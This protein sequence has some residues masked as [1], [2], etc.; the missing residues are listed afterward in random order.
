MWE[1][2][3][4]KAP[5]G[6]EVVKHRF[7]VGLDSSYKSYAQLF[8]GESFDS[9]CNRL[10][11]WEFGFV[12]DNQLRPNQKKPVTQVVGVN[13]VATSTWKNDSNFKKR[14]VCFKFKEG[15]CT[16]GDRCKFSHPANK[17]NP[18]TVDT[19]KVPVAEAEKERSSKVQPVGV[20][21][22]GA[23]VSLSPLSLTLTGKKTPEKLCAN[24]NNIE[25]L[26]ETF[27]GQDD[28]GV[29]ANEEVPKSVELEISS[30][31]VSPVYFRGGFKAQ[32]LVDCGAACNLVDASYSNELLKSD[33][34]AVVRNLARPVCVIFGNSQS[35]FSQKVLVSRCRFTSEG[36]SEYHSFLIVPQLEPKMVLGRPELEA[37][38]EIFKKFLRKLPMVSVDVNT[39]DVFP[40]EFFSID[41]DGGVRLHVPHLEKASVTPFT[42]SVRSRPEVDKKILGHL[43]AKLEE[44]G[45]I[46]QIS[47]SDAVFIHEPVLVDK[48]KEQDRPKI[49]P[50]PEGEEDRF[51]LTN[52]L[53]PLNSM[54]FDPKSQTWLVQEDL[55][56]TAELK[57]Q[58]L[59]Q[60]QATAYQICSSWPVEHR[61]SFFGI[62]Y[63]GGYHTCR[64]NDS[65]GRLMAFR[66]PD[67][68]IYA[69][70]VLSQGWRLSVIYFRKCVKYVV[71]RTIK[72]YPEA[73]ENVTV[74]NFLDDILGGTISSEKCLVAKETLI[75]GLAEHKVPVV[76]KKCTGPSP[77]TQ[78]CGL[79]FDKFE[80]KPSPSRTKIT[81]SVLEVVENHC[82]SIQNRS[83][84]IT[85]IRS[86]IGIYN[87]ALKWFNPAEKEKLRDLNSII[88]QLNSGVSLDSIDRDSVVSTIISLGRY[89]LE[90]LRGLFC[91]P[92][93]CSVVVS[94]A[95]QNSFGSVTLTLV[96]IS[97]TKCCSPLPFLFAN[98]TQIVCKRLGL[99]PSQFVLL[100][101]K[102]GGG[103]FSKNE[104]ARS[105]TVKEKIGMLRAVSDSRDCLSDP[106]FVICDNRNSSF[107]NWYTKEVSLNARIVEDLEFFNSYVSEVIF[108]PRSDATITLVDQIAREV[109]L[110][111]SVGACP[112]RAR[113][114]EGDEPPAT[115]SGLDLGQV[116]EPSG[117]DSSDD[118]LLHPEDYESSLDSVFD[119]SE[120]RADLWYEPLRD[121]ELVYS[122]DETLK[123][124][125]DADY[126][127][128]GDKWFTSVSH[129]VGP[130]LLVI[131]KVLSVRVVRRCHIF[132]H[133]GK[134]GMLNM[135]KSWGM[136]VP[137][138]SKLIDEVPCQSCDEAKVGYCPPRTSILKT[139]EVMASVSMDYMFIPEKQ[140]TLLVMR[141]RLTGF[142]EVSEVPNKEAFH[143]RSCLFNWFTRFGKPNVLVCD[144]EKSFQSLEVKDLLKFFG[145]EMFTTPMYSPMSNGDCER[146]VRTLSDGL[147]AEILSSPPGLSVYEM[148]K[149]V[150]Y[151]VNRANGSFG[152]VFTYSDPCPVIQFS[153][154]VKN[155]VGD[156]SPGVPVLLKMEK[157]SRLYPLFKDHNLE[158]KELC[159]DNVYWLQDRDTKIQFP[160]KV[161]RDRLKQKSMVKIGLELLEP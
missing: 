99:D 126:V 61:E 104:A 152:R 93:L 85:Y 44:Q 155:F 41:S 115:R 95:N 30:P 98:I 66:G 17:A 79:L 50:L 73:F 127:L 92:G 70:R 40:V 160:F 135:L 86:W 14:G 8:S 109:N 80:I 84:F 59:S 142:C 149:L 42:E 137:N 58:T 81:E 56:G 2:S 72:K 141:D 31:W 90:S 112:V 38:P 18:G 23:S 1:A 36:F 161:R 39:S 75:K 5:W 45:C 24:M 134:A 140:L 139:K 6:E 108:V 32:A 154:P 15:N 106:V 43:I 11:E 107:K 12:A 51:R 144:N 4:L 13:A 131:P 96:P 33:N 74:E 148:L 68:R 83:E 49:W 22:D 124:S 94:D 35:S 119:L 21:V 102:W 113:V 27:A 16:W 130:S 159:G 29:V 147:R 37:S 78:F 116:H 146:T 128:I 53:R 153:A 150:Q 143:V 54:R 156:L 97:L 19:S 136:Y 52:D 121:D 120:D 55:I 25:V 57:S 7:K 62:D 87:Y 47:E 64:I 110:V 60:G 20:K 34:Q 77:S 111:M 46:R 132:G 82:K 9:L 26:Q 125:S 88:K 151:R 157:S 158:I 3:V 117:V 100:P 122:E 28:S 129:R 76:E 114:D 89:Y 69:Y 105:S 138:A 133:A 103:V 67:G 71:E 63:K 10:R 65:L 91:G 123:Y 145:V 101:S 118:D 48:F